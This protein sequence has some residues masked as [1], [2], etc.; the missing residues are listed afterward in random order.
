MQMWL[1]NI[2]GAV[3]FLLGG[4]A[5][6]L[7]FGGSASTG[8][9]PILFAGASG[10]QTFAIGTTFWTIRSATL[11]AWTP[12]HLTP[13]SG[14]TMRASA[15]SGG[16]T[17]GALAAIMRGRSNVLPGAIM[18]SLFGTAGQWAY[19]ST[20]GSPK[21]ESEGPKKN[22]WE[23]VGER[24]WSPMKVLS[25]EEYATMLRERQLKVDVEIAVIDEKIAALKKG[26][27]ENESAEKVDDGG[28]EK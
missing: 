4:T 11:S 9:A 7:K 2:T 20:F 5:G 15:I 1:T 24:S 14:D 12:S 8:A 18:F 17:G 25:N 27:K 28:S 21:L 3:G 26:I 6:I 13:S 22:F 23:R 19:N 10:L 16:I